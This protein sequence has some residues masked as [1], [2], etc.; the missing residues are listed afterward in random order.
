M[1]TARRGLRLIKAVHTLAWAFFVACIMVIP[2]LAGRGRFT[3][4]LL[5]IAVGGF[6]LLWIYAAAVLCGVRG[7]CL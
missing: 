3:A 7:V 1:T 6:A 4:A 5:F 2:V